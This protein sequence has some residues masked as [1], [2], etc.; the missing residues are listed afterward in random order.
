[1]HWVAVS[2][3]CWVQRTLSR[4]CSQDLILG[5]WKKCLKM[6]GNFLEVSVNPF[7]P[8]LLWSYL[9]TCVLPLTP[10]W[11]TVKILRSLPHPFRSHLRTR[12]L[13]WSVIS[14][15]VK[16]K[17]LT[18]QW[19]WTHLIPALRRQRQV[20]LYEF[21]ANLVYRAS[22]RTAKTTQWDPVSKNQKEEEEERRRK[23]RRRSSSSSSSIA[24]CYTLCSAFIALKCFRAQGSVSFTPIILISPT[25]L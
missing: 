2:L 15:G 13:L 1:M 6:T 8:V 23:K 5:V 24:L 10:G 17:H 19:W 11:K 25:H 14:D 3:D 16:N 9:P 7:F 21:E 12:E 20:D 18:G 22:S 4:R